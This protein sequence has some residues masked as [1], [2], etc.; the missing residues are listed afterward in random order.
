[1]PLSFAAAAGAAIGEQPWRS[2]RGSG[3]APFA[4]AAAAPFEH[5]Q[6]HHSSTTCRDNAQFSEHAGHRR[7]DSSTTLSVSRIGEIF[8]ARHRLADLLVPGDQ[9]SV[10]HRLGKLRNLD[11]GWT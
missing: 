4:G 10:G 5:G 8:I 11:F 2:R 7:R 9:R 1:M 6:H 3:A